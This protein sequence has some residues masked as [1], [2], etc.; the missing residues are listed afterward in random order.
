[1][2]ITEP[3]LPSLSRRSL[4]AGAAAMLV[5]FVPLLFGDDDPDRLTTTILA[6]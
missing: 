4:M 5:P 3:N 2:N 6:G 1:M